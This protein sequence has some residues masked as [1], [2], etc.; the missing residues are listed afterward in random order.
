[1]NQFHFKKFSV[2]QIDEVH[3]VG[4]DAMLLGAFAEVTNPKNILDIGTG[5]GVLGL[6]L[7]QKYPNANISAIDNNESAYKLAK[8]NLESFIDK[9]QLKVLCTDFLSLS[10]KTRYDLVISNPPFYR[11]AKKSPVENRNTARHEVFLPFKSLFSKVKTVLTS[12]GVFWIIFPF[13]NQ[14]EIMLY[15]SEN[16]LSPINQIQIN[17]KPNHPVRYIMSF[18]LTKP[19]KVNKSLFTIR[20]DKGK[21]TSEYLQL[22]KEFHGK[23]L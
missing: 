4:T 6:M 18:E 9:S 12:N 20:D 23:A 8:S 5:T 7:A 17:G 22:T 3:K 2:Y 10:D 1:M 15:A 14:Q 21:Y 11:N 16:N 13:E 19:E